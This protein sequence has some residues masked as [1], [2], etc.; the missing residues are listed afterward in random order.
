MKHG[1]QAP[2]GFMNHD[3]V[4]YRYRIDPFEYLARDSLRKP[5]RKK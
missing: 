4:T 2:I 3:R 1:T 5:E